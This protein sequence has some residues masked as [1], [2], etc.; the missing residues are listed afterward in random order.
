VVLAC[1]GSVD[2]FAQACKRTL[3]DAAQTLAAADA[4]WREVSGVIV[5]LSDISNFAT[6]NQCY[7]TCVPQCSPPTRFAVCMRLQEPILFILSLQVSR[8]SSRHMH[9]ESISLW[10]PA[11]IGPYS[12]AQLYPGYNRE[13]GNLL[14]VSGQI[15]L[16][17]ERMLL[18]AAEGA[19]REQLHAQCAQISRNLAA[20]VEANLAER[21]KPL[22]F[23]STALCTCQCL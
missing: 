20:I 3:A 23:F 13:C 1:C 4:E 14:L 6:F 10:A 12:Q 16:I 9:V 21:C 15:G 11:N 18:A 22:I 19:Q 8:G 7:A 5:Q 17:P 2:E